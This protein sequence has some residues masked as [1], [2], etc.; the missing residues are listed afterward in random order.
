MRIECEMCGAYTEHPKAIE[1]AEQTRC[2]PVCCHIGSLFIAKEN[3]Y[4][5]NLSINK[6]FEVAADSPE[7][8]KEKAIEAARQLLDSYNSLEINRVEEVEEELSWDNEYD[9]K[10]ITT[11]GEI[12]HY[13]IEADGAHIAEEVARE[14]F[15]DDY[16]N[17]TIKILEVKLEEENDYEQQAEIAEYEKVA[18]VNPYCI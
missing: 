5:I 18:A 3:T 1:I 2:C 6:T 4:N 14:F 10:I 8:A 12:H 11:E 13:G 17:E 9:V 16:P 15:A 7:E